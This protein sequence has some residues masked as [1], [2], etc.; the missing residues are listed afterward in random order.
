MHYLVV[1]KV[2]DYPVIG[3][4]IFGL[5]RHTDILNPNDLNGGKW[6]NI[7][8]EF[9]DY[10]S[11]SIMF[12]KLVLNLFHERCADYGKDVPYEGDKDTPEELFQKRKQ[13]VKDHGFW[14][15]DEN[16]YAKVSGHFDYLLAGGKYDMETKD[17]K[18]KYK[19]VVAKFGKVDVFVLPDFECRFT[20]HRDVECPYQDDDEVWV[21]DGYTYCNW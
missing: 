17:Q 16:V 8:G 1:A 3:D 5:T 2:K 18:A 13:F 20:K 6:E 4:L 21:L 10:W 9:Q 14:A 15:D 7:S 12:P 19:D 11:N